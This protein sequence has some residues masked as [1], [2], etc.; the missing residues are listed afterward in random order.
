MICMALRPLEC[1]NQKLTRKGWTNPYLLK[2]GVVLTQIHN[3][4]GH[5][6]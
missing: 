5:L 6:Q 3:N 4:I 2:P 1:K